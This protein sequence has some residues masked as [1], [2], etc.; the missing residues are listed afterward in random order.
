VSKNGSHDHV[1]KRRRLS[2]VSKALKLAKRVSVIQKV[3]VQRLKDSWYRI[4]SLT[5]KTSRDHRWL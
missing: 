5:V 2:R 1:G 3:L 4:C